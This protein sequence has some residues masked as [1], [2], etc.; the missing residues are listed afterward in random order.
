[1]RAQVKNEGRYSTL[2]NLGGYLLAAIFF[3][4][5]TVLAVILF[6]LGKMS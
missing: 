3:I 2:L 4:V 6:L 1:L 5:A